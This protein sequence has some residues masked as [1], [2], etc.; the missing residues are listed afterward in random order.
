MKTINID[1]FLNENAVEFVVNGKK[2][3]VRDV[4]MEHAE[5]LSKEDCD[6]KVV[7]SKVLGCDPTDLESYGAIGVMKIVAFINE[8]LLPK[9]SQ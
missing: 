8:N 5:A 9:V 1:D 7:L 3:I 6:R 2:F 4:S